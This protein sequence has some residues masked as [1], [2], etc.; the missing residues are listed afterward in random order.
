MMFSF[1]FCVL[2]C[3]YIW[4]DFLFVQWDYFVSLFHLHHDTALQ[5]IVGGM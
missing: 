3:H 4:V 5:L 1:M 2:Y